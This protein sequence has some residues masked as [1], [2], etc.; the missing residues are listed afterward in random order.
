VNSSDHTAESG[1][2]PFGWARFRLT[3]A[4]PAVPMPV[5]RP[6]GGLPWLELASLP[7]LVLI[8]LIAAW[9]SQSRF[10]PGPGSVA[11]EIWDL[12]RGGPLLNDFAVTFL[13]ALI[14]FAMA[15]VIGTA[16]GVALGR[17][18]W[19]D[20]L[21]SPWIVVGLNIPAIVVGILCYISL[22]LSD[23]A[24]ILAVVI[25]KVP[26]VAMIMREGVRALS[27]EYDELAA[28]FRM[29]WSRHARLVLLPQLMP[30]LLAAARAG[31]SLVWKMVL[32]FEVLGSDG[33][34][35]FRVGLYFQLFDVTGI[36]AYACCFVAVIL[37]LEYLVLRPIEGRVLAWRK[38]RA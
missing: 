19:A 32:V 34:V 4:A 1:T 17:T 36:L 23:G 22:G 24:L 12:A 13:R 26:L 7:L 28:T 9:M 2:A 37:A 31:L 5:A 33:G 20:R 3:N 29:P 38:D 16:V 35:G 27:A 30:H 14:G 21:F 18:P 6:A 15:M 25:N 10:L 8:W 11:V